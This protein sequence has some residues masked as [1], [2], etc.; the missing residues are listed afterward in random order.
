MPRPTLETMQNLADDTV[1][2]Y[3][4]PVVTLLAAGVPVTLLADLF[5]AGGP[6]SAHIYRH[7]PSVDDTSWLHADPDG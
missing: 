5:P 4:W 7:E 1:S 2:G 6:D 3:Q